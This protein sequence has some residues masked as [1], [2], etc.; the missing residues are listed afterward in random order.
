MNAA[1]DENGIS[2]LLAATVSEVA[3]PIRISADSTTHRLSVQD[4]SAGVNGGPVN[5]SRDENDIPVLLA[6][7]SAD[8]VTP[9]V[10][11]GCALGR[12]LIDRN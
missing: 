8:G 2:T 4:S 5:A 6:T 10:V 11:Y 1:K 7:S 9:V 3:T 12:L